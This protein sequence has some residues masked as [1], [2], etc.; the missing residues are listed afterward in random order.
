MRK[1]ETFMLGRFAGTLPHPRH[2][3]DYDLVLPGL[4][5][6]IIRMAEDEQSHCPELESTTVAATEKLG[7]WG[8]ACGLIVAVGGLGVAG[9]L[10]W[11][12]DT[13]AA[14]VIGSGELAAL[15]AVF[16][17]GNRPRGGRQRA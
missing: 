2:L 16:A 3:E 10:G 1:V 15:V 11:H 5:D 9:D 12:G 8:M 13:V 6:R 4:A 14:T 17:V 7:T